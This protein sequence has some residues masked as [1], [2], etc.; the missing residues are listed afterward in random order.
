MWRALIALL[1][2]AALLTGEAH[3]D[4]PLQY[5]GDVSAKKAIS[6]HNAD[7]Q[8]MAANGNALCLPPDAL[9]H[10]WGL[11]PSGVPGY[12]HVPFVWSANSFCTQYSGWTGYV[13]FAN[14]PT[15]PPEHGGSWL[16]AEQTAAQAAQINAC[17]PGAKLV[18]P[19]HH[20]TLNVSPADW[21]TR[22]WAS[23][24]AYGGDPGAIVA[25]GFHIYPNTAMPGMSPAKMI[26]HFYNVLLPPGRLRTLP[27]WI[28]E[29]GWK[30]NWSSPYEHSM[31][32]FNETIAHPRVDYVFG[33][34]IV[35]YGQNMGFVVPGTQ[36]YYTA[37]GRGWRD[38][39]E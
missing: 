19:N 13:L 27:L 21:M 26:D 30:N 15:N 37:V 1:L 7:L 3:A 10:N 32:W 23:Y 14:E 28:T 8:A 2:L 35:D 4:P 18:G 17:A 36:A 22:F 9:H 39:G 20:P 11:Q 33:Y 25:N 6:G 31:K 34:S 5:C 16:T 38:A 24:E 29:T 12:Q